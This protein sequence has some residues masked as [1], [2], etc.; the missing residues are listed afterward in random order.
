M[1]I[2]MVAQTH[3]RAP[4]T[5]AA[6][7]VLLTIAGCTNLRPGT[8]TTRRT[9]DSQSVVSNAVDCQRLGAPIDFE[10]HGSNSVGGTVAPVGPRLNLRLQGLRTVVPVLAPGR[11]AKSENRFAGVMPF[12][13][14]TGGT[15]AV[16]VASL[17][18]ADVGQAGPPRFIQPQSFEWV[19]LCGKRFKNG[20]Y[21]FESAKTY[22]VQ[23]WDSPDRELEVMIRRLP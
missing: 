7:L 15:Y 22:L 6:L 12:R 23:L 5:S 21:T 2:A 14:E 13:I 11:Q 9:E 8:E 10:A 18:W 1:M 17:A 19:T 20:Q 3:M 4:R 16:L